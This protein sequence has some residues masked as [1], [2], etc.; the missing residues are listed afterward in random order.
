[1]MRSLNQPERKW[2]W[3]GWLQPRRLVRW[4]P[5]L[6]LIVV[7]TWLLL[8]TVGEIPEVITEGALAPYDIRADR[9]YV[10]V[11]EETTEAKRASAAST[12]RRVYDYDAD[13][14]PGVVER[15]HAAFRLAR[16][17]FLGLK[18]GPREAPP[19]ELVA[20]LRPQFALALAVT[21]SDA[22]WEALV[23]ERFSPTI[24]ETFVRVVRELLRGPVVDNL[25]LLRQEREGGITLRQI[26]VRD[27]KQVVEETLARW[28]RIDAIASIDQQ[29]GKVRLNALER[30][31]APLKEL[32]VGLLQS[33]C[34]P[35]VQ[36]TKERQT[37]AR[38][39][40]APISESIKPG[41]LIARRYERY[42]PRQVKLLRAIRAQKATGNWP[43]E[44]AGAALF[45]ATTLL[46]LHGF[47]R[48]FIRAYRP[49]WS[50]LLFLGALVVLMVAV[51]RV[52]G[53]WADAMANVQWPLPA[54]AYYYLIP[55][56]AGG[57]MVRFLLNAETAALFSVAIACLAGLL[58]P[59]QPGFAPYVLLA[60]LAGAG[61][62]AQADKRALIIRA[63]VYTGAIAAILVLAI[64]LLRAGSLSEIILPI[65]IGWLL[66]CTLGGA[67]LA[68]VLVL[69]LTP[70][71]ESACGYTSDIK[72]LE[73]ANLNHPL[74][75]ELV[76]RAPG[77]YHHSHLVGILAE[78]GASAVGANALLARVGAYYHDIGK[79]RKPTYFTE[80]M[81]GESLHDRLTPHMSALIIASHVREG[82]ELARMYKLP[83]QIADMIPQH[84]GTKRIGYFYEQASAVAD[85]ALGGVDEK[86]FRY[87][88][89][90]PQT[91]EAGILLLSD[92]TEG[93]VRALP[94]K[95]SARIQQMVEGIINKSFAD[96]QLDEC[97]LTL[98]DLH[99]IANAF[100]RILMGIYHQRIEYPRETLQLNEEDVPVVET[101]DQPDDRHS[102]ADETK[103]PSRQTH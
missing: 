14:M 42:S 19:A 18:L 60:N 70:V 78:A 23:T 85:P 38:E 66:V 12:L 5:F 98:K 50:D 101:E 34:V 15:I 65:D 75:R 103:P 96:G 16:N 7:L 95:T 3:A 54:R 102:A 100:T 71:A 49:A 27:G 33:N 25:E 28:E 44:A 24:E 79:I 11:D 89:P 74:L 51:L 83:Q 53:I 2:D 64:H 86:D 47:G 94:E 80:N 6:G 36:V 61:T 21:V 84:H 57:M 91:R 76:I 92:G 63:G 32:V 99:D 29:R 9:S 39:S 37:S 67:L 48:R 4:L 30:H 31:R 10:F 58:Y 13:A 56:A 35:N 81:K 8:L 77:T 88:G 26:T 41:E 93:A 59:N 43:L 46:L 40:V 90:K 1:M 17:A 55:V 87:P 62:I 52:G 69:T 72:L 20:E 45:V 22:Q 73:L 68:A 97:D 82:L